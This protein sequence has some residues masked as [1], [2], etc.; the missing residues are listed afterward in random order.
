MPSISN[1][2]NLYPY[3]AKYVCALDESEPCQEYLSNVVNINGEGWPIALTKSGDVLFLS[4]TES[5][6]TYL[7]VLLCDSHLGLGVDNCEEMYQNVVTIFGGKNTYALREDGKVI[8]WGANTNGELGQGNI[9]Y[10]SFE[11]TKPGL[12]CADYNSKCNNYL[13]NVVDIIQVNSPY[14]GY[15][16]FLNQDGD[17]FA[18]GTLPEKIFSMTDLPFNL[19]M[20]SLYP[21]KINGLKFNNLKDIIGDFDDIYYLD[22]NKILHGIDGQW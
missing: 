14:H 4:K 7:P 16:I 5:G 9:T 8:S 1:D 13:D 3:E 20:R 11:D 19:S 6:D 22:N 18:S 17:I 15:T 2:N 12:V 10:N 21:V